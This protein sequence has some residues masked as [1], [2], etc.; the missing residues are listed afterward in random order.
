MEIKGVIDKIDMKKGVGKTGK[1]FTR[2]VFVIDGKSYST[3]DEKI[4]N[5]SL[6]V[7]DSVIMNGIQEG[8]F[9]NMKTIVKS[10]EVFEKKEA[11]NEVVKGSQ[12]EDLLRQ[13]LAEIKSITQLKTGDLE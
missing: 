12:V 7:G 6:K 13:I 2:W 3:F 9:F 1:P 10:S 4:G 5:S 11:V 8:Q